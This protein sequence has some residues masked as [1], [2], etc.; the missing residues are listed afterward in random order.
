MSL[1]SAALS[2][3]AHMLSPVLSPFASVFGA[4]WRWT[5]LFQND[6]DAAARSRY[7]I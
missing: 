2:T 1:M 6:L 7:Q 3:G 4:F 5:G